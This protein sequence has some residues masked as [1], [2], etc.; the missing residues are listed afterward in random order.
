MISNKHIYRVLVTEDVR[1]VKEIYVSAWS[2]DDAFEYIDELLD[3]GDERVEC[4]LDDFEEVTYRDI[5]VMEEQNLR[6]TRAP[7]EILDTGMIPPEE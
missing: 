6:S 1:L 3:T 4:T 2:K 7:D 5:Y